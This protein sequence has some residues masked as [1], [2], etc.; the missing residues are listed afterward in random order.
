MYRKILVPI[1]GSRTST[2]G[3]EEAIRLAKG[4]NA[5]L[6]I[7]HAVDEAVVAYGGDIVP[8]YI[9]E[10]LESM[11]EG[12][13]RIIAKAVAKARGRGVKVKSLLVEKF[14]GPVADIIVSHAKKQRADLIVIGTH[15]RRGVTRLVMGS[16]A[17][18]VVRKS[19][20]PVLLVRSREQTRRAK[21]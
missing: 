5:T 15:G 20:V 3:L 10:L 1:D 12:G 18:G 8:V 21:R 13:K 16:D 7:L 9:N 14:V 4:R 6:V 11:R 2:R 19:P 17:E